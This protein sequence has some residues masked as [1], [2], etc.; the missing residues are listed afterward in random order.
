MGRDTGRF[1]IKRERKEERNGEELEEVFLGR[2]RK[3]N[4]LRAERPT[5]HRSRDKQYPGETE[6]D[7]ADSE[8]WKC[9]G[10]F[11]QLLWGSNQV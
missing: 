8:T 2:H 10:E 3:V 5:L 4:S 1:F 11:A 6:G 9:G 7:W